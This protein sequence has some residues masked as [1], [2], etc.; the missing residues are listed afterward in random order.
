MIDS[1]T[2]M[3]CIHIKLFYFLPYIRLIKKKKMSE[4][5]GG[6]VHKC[7]KCTCRIG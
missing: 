1:E 7:V 5:V 2:Y 6:C 3:G 4:W